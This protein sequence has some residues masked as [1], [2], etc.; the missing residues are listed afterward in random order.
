MRKITQPLSQ[1]HTSTLPFIQKF[2]IEP[3]PK[4]VEK[5][6]ANNQG[7]ND[8]GYVMGKMSQM[9]MG[10]YARRTQVFV[11]KFKGNLKYFGSH[12]SR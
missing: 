4:E 1:N 2:K 11:N 3:F 5:C 7:F 12:K 10:K 8:S 6:K 9:M